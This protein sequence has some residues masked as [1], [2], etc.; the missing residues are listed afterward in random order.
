MGTK[1]KA[2]LCL[3]S[4]FTVDSWTA[5]PLARSDLSATQPRALLCRVVCLP[6]L[7]HSS[8]RTLLATQE[9]EDSCIV[10]HATGGPDF[11]RV[12]HYS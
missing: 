7:P 9:I 4:E 11:L 2:D 8:L 6:A 3:S 10:T 1:N 12:Q 5:L